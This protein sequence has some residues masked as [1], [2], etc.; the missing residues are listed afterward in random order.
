[1]DKFSSKSLKEQVYDHLR[2]EIH[3]HR[4]RPGSAIHMDEMCRSLGI[5][6]TPLRDALMQ[7]AVEGFVVI[8]PRRGVAVNTLTL[9]DIRHSY[10]VIGALEGEALRATVS[11]LSATEIAGMRTRNARMARAIARG[12]FF[13]FYEHNLAFHDV[14]LRPCANPL[15]IDSV[16]SLKRRLYD[17]VS[18]KQWIREW[19]EVSIGEHERLV[20]FIEAG[21]G[22]GAA[23]YVREVHW[24][25]AVQEPFI[26]RY[27]FPEGTADIGKEKAR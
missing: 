4:L 12:D 13:R 3:R 1:M 5:S 22:E 2:G 23:A 19:E 9:D 14:Y 25:F 11:R 16:T 6:R 15:L 17:F 21:D 8:S 18:A 24:S 7:L 26:R 10:Q 20:G 27:Y